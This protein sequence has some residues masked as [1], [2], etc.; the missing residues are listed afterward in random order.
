M[1]RGVP[2]RALAFAVALSLVVAGVVLV[3]FDDRHG[4]WV[5]LQIVAPLSVLTVLAG[6]WIARARPGGL[7]RQF[8]LVAGLGAV[9]LAAGVALFVWLMFASSHDA[10]MTVLLAVYAGSLALWVARRLGSQALDELDAVR[11]TLAAVGEGRRDVR[12]GLAGD[13]ELARLGRQVDDTIARLD[14][15]ERARREL[16][17]A[18]SHDLRTPI[19]SLGLLATAIDD[20]IVDESTRREYAAR[21]NT[22][23]KQLAALID[24][25]FDL[26]RLHAQEL[27]WTMERLPVDE[28]VRDA[29]EAMRPTAD[30][31]SVVML[32]TVDGVGASHGNREQL[33]RVLFNLI[34]NAIHHTPPDG[35]VTVLA[36]DVE[37]GVEIEVA[38][39]GTG[40]SSEQRDRVFEPFFR[41]DAARQSPGAG[42]G[43]AISRAIVEAHGG[44]IWLEEASAGTRVRFRLPAASLSGTRQ[45]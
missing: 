40:I 6:E 11:A 13:D 42:L 2:L 4:A 35:S 28:L 23:V 41:G 36:T 45:A 8:V 37:G 12:V 7:R 34:Q 15:E 39:T 5:T 43:L 20:S 44:A 24:D 14:R 21:M 31:R 17:A 16:F 25:L 32:A 38:D 26:T 9:Q 30:D 27:E 33:R 22:H 18:V 10:L 19:T 29:V 1:G 3:H